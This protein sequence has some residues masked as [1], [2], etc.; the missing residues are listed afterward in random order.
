MGETVEQRPGQALRAERLGPFVEGKRHFFPGGGY[1]R[2]S[3]KKARKLADK[4]KLRLLKGKPGLPQKDPA[5]NVPTFAEASCFAREAKRGPLSEDRQARAWK[6]AFD[7]YVPDKIAAKPV[8]KIVSRD[9][10][11]I[12]TPIW[13]S[14]PAT[15][16]RLRTYLTYQAHLTRSTAWIAPWG[17]CNGRRIGPN[18][19]HDAMSVARIRFPCRCGA[20]NM[21]F[22]RNQEPLSPAVLPHALKEFNVGAVPHGLRASFRTW[23]AEQGVRDRVAEACLAHGPK[24]MVGKAY[25][26]TTFFEERR[27]VMERWAQSLFATDP[28]SGDRAFDDF[29]NPADTVAD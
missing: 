3:L 18:G 10:V 22:V 20:W 11:A 4:V 19:L 2:V 7:R 8:S 29:G 9:M 1:P 27:D 6:S 21:R 13:D 5:P 15:A 16:T 17:A 26:R 25:I 23:A 24:T 14:M 28:T 12:L